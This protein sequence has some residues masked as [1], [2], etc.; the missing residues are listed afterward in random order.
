MLERQPPDRRLAPMRKTVSLSALGGATAAAAVLGL[1]LGQAAVSEI[2]P[3]YYQGPAIHPRDRG[4]AIE[5]S[6]EPQQPQ[7]LFASLYGW[8]EGQAARAEECSDCAPGHPSY[9][10]YAEPVQLATAYDERQD[11]RIAAPAPAVTVHR[12][13]ASDDGQSLKEE[14]AQA[15]TIDDE[16]Q[17]RRKA[18][19]LYA[20]YP[21]EEPA[22]PVEDQE[23]TVIYAASEQ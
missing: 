17:R 12:A 6:W 20:S 3:I 14:A 16:Q 19:D 23:V 9:H 5:E 11:E 8:A 10:A 15:D 4:A 2:D 13:S 1:H 22:Y 7:T 18:V 21:V